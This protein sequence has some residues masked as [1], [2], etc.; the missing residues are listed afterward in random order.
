MSLQ[1]ATNDRVGKFTS[2]RVLTYSTGQDSGHLKKAYLIKFGQAKL[3][4]RG[5]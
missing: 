2:I 4:V 1:S 3:L 5:S